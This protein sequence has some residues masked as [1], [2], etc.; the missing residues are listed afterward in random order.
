MSGRFGHRLATARFL[1]LRWVFRSYPLEKV[2]SGAHEPRLG[3]G[4][5]NLE[6]RRDLGKL[7][8][9]H[10]VQHEDHGSVSIHCG[11]VGLCGLDLISNA[12]LALRVANHLSLGG[13]GQVLDRLENTSGPPACAQGVEGHVRRHGRSPR[14]QAASS[15]E[16]ATHQRQD[17]LLEGRLDKVVV[18][19]L[20]PAQHSIK[21]RL[22]R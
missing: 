5:R 13:I 16:A 10:V 8:P 18:I 7:M 11:Q 3:S 1:P 14:R 20:A 9:Q 4:D 17:D 6:H 15:R 19:P 22:D 12:D 21:R 2:A